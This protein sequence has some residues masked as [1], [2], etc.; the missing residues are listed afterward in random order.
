ME[1]EWTETVPIAV[2]GLVFIC[3]EMCVCIAQCFQLTHL[4]PPKPA[5]AGV[6]LK[7]PPFW[8][9]ACLNEVFRVLNVTK[10]L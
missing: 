9:F 4:Y 6:L 2:T 10:L 7:Q 3:T 8:L 1:A 5:W